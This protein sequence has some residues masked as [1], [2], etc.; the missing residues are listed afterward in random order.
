MNTYALCK[1][2]VLVLL[3][4]LGSNFL[5]I[6]QNNNYQ[7]MIQKT[8]KEVTPLSKSDCRLVAYDDKEDA[9]SAYNLHLF[10][11]NGEIFTTT[12]YSNKTPKTLSAD[13]SSTNE[14]FIEET[15]WQIADNE[16]T[17]YV[18][19]SRFGATTSTVTNNK[20]KIIKLTSTE[21]ILKL[22]DTK[23]SKL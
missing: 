1:K 15:K 17:W 23:T 21:L 20:Y 10:K 18:K 3:I 5:L 16:L 11:A 22:I 9:E 19:S 2:I 7:T 12:H 14:P 4:S 8:W 13:L 6:G